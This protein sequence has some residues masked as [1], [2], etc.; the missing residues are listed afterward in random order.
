MPSEALELVEVHEGEVVNTPLTEEERAEHESRIARIHATFGEIGLKSLEI[1]RDL[2]WI[3]DNKTY[4]EEYDDFNSFCLTELGRDNSTI[5]RQLKDAEF[6]EKLLLEAASDSERASILTLRESNTRFLRGL[7]E[8]VQTAFWK[9]SFALGSEMLAK[10]DNGAIEPSTSYF[11]SLASNMNE[12]LENGGLHIDGEFVSVDSVV[13]SAKVEGVDE[14]TAKAILLKAGVSE[15][16]YEALQRQAQHIKERSIKADV[17]TLK[18]NINVRTDVNGSD[19]P[20]LVDSRGNELDLS[21]ILLSFNTRFVAL[22]LK[23]PI[24]D[25]TEYD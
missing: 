1:W 15:A 6:K 12:I 2:Q 5:Y 18:G 16:A 9:L 24:R 25:I 8:E 11:E 17:T 4:R 13:E 20:V 10:K 21:E 23:S 3:K 19:Y 22:T 7:P 14:A